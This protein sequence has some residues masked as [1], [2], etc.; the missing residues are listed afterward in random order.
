MFSFLSARHPG[1]TLGHVVTHVEHFKEIPDCFPNWLHHFTFPGTVC[2]DSDFSKSLATCLCVLGFTVILV[3]VMSLLIA[4][5][6]FISLVTNDAMH[7]FMC[8]LATQIG[9]IVKSFALF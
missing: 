2:K 4:L 5:L 1:E 6:V 7:H 9:R 3:C 8:L